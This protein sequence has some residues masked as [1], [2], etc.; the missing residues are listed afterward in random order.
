MS[1]HVEITMLLLTV[2]GQKRSDRRARPSTEPARR[3]L[4]ICFP[5]QLRFTLEHLLSPTRTARTYPTKATAMCARRLEPAN[6]IIAPP[7]TWDQR[8]GSAEASSAGVT[9]TTTL[10]LEE[11]MDSED[12]ATTTVAGTAGPRPCRTARTQRSTR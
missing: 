4:S 8:A 11:A 10:A 3:L 9:R 2:R 5:P 1:R 7:L 12:S 6:V